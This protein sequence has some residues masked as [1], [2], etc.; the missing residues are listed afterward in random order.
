MA[1]AGTYT[2]TGTDPKTGKPT[3]SP[4]YSGTGAAVTTGPNARNIPYFGT[5]PYG[6]SCGVGNPSSST[7]TPAAMTAKC[8]GK[9]TATFIWQPASGQ[10]ATTDPPPT[11][12]VVEQDLD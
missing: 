10:T 2:W 9:I 8:S 4:V 1:R 5:G 11:S 12:A 7:P 3:Q 6:A